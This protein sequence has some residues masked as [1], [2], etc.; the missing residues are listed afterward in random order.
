MKR[1]LERLNR[2]AE[3]AEGGTTQPATTEANDAQNQSEGGN[4]GSEDIETLKKAHESL[5]KDI[6]KQREISALLK[7]T[8]GLDSS[9]GGDELKK[10]LNDLKE[11]KQKEAQEAEEKRLAGMTEM[12][13]LQEE[14]KNL[15]AENLNYSTE[16]S[17]IKSEVAKNKFVVDALTP[18]LINAGAHEKK[19]KTAI[20]AYMLE[21]PDFEKVQDVAENVKSWLANEDNLGFMKASV[22]S[23]AGGGLGGTDEKGATLKDE[24]GKL[25]KQ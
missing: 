21:N 14:I 23:G 13:R 5:T 15:K 1:F 16:N 18:A 17:T 11:Q 24:I 6:G 4:T 3:G 2:D 12:E 8:L 19:L 20:K 7:E 9:I 10:A 25:F 22:E